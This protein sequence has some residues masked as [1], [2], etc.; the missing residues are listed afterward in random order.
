M[1]LLVISAPSVYPEKIAETPELYESFAAYPAFELFHAFPDDLVDE[2]LQIKAYPVASSYTYRDFWDWSSQEP[3][4]F[5]AKH[6][7]LA[8]CRTLKPFPDGYMDQLALLEEEL[9][10]VNSPR[11]ILKHL[12]ADFL[13]QVAEKWIAPL[14][15]TRE[16]EEASEFFLKHGEI[17]AK[18]TNSCGGKGV[19]RVRKIS[20]QEYSIE[21]H[22]LGS[23]TFPS[24]QEVFTALFSKSG[25]AFQLVQ[26]L[27]GVDQGD[28]RVLVV[29]GEIYGSYLRLS[30]SGA[31]VHNISAGGQYHLA[32]IDS[33][34]RSAIEETAR[35]YQEM[36]IHTLGYDFLMGDEGQWQISEI[37]AGNIAGYSLH[38]ELTGSLTRKR[39]CQWIEDFA[40]R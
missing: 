4:S 30:D 10:F 17:V 21:N 2:Q 39:L 14:I 8:F 40:R 23:E 3:V 6:F 24:L 31:W 19:W 18:Q 22:Y 9:K 34:E 12:K 15:V 37:N 27:K 20:A 32:E 11:G 36:G 1:R 13:P 29:D 7:D 25:D 16:I 33:Y 26:F 35:T 38:E 5:S 28:K